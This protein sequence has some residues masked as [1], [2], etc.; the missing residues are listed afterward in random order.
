MQDYT[1]VI[2]LNPDDPRAYLNRGTVHYRSFRNAKLALKDLDKAISL[3]RDYAP[4]YLNCG[5]ILE[6]RGDLKAAFQL[7]TAGIQA[8]PKD[9]RLHRYRG[10]LNLVRQDPNS[11]I[12]DLSQAIDINPVYAEAY[13]LRAKAYIELGA[14]SAAL[15][16]ATK[17]EALGYEVSGAYIDGM[18]KLI[19]HDFEVKRKHAR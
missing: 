14:Y 11:A 17:A 9:A 16:D 2:E 18:T 5:V 15:D 4:A 8:A 10:V 1:K 13:F 19:D 7:H 6:Q 12:R 3:K